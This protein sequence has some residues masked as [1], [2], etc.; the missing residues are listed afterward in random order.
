MK[1]IFWLRMLAWIKRGAVALE[2]IAESQQQMAEAVVAPTRKRKVP[3]FAEV[4]TPTVEERN[5]EWQR[6]RDAEVFGEE[7]MNDEK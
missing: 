4:H 3:R 1:A 7:N 6:Q 2:S 5:Q